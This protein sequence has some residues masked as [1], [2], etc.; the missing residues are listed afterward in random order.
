MSMWRVHENNA[1]LL[2][3]ADS[4]HVWR[5]PA[6]VNKPIA[7]TLTA[8]VSGDAS[9]NKARQVPYTA[10]ETRVS[11][12]DYASLFVRYV[13]SPPPVSV[14]RVASGDDGFIPSDAVSPTGAESNSLLEKFFTIFMKPGAVYFVKFASGSWA[15]NL[16][17]AKFP[18][19]IKLLGFDTGLKVLSARIESGY[20]TFDIML[21]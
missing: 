21:S 5:F 6:N 16:K 19:S 12:V 14:P 11:P 2:Y 17:D 15:V 20:V 13:E 10:L 7:E 9:I 1:D 4:G 18:H 8:K 3:F